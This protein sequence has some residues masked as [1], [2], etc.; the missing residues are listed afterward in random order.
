[1]IHP[2]PAVP[3]GGEG[4][5]QDDVHLEVK[6]DFLLDQLPFCGDL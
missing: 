1:M 4:A 3:E 5:V 2:P 6:M